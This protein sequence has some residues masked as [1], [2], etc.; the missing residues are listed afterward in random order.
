MFV[1]VSSLHASL[2]FTCKPTRRFRQG[3]LTER[4]AQLSTVDLLVLASLDQLVLK[5]KILF[6]FFTKLATLI[7]RSTILS[8]PHQ[9]VFPDWGVR[10]SLG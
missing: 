6:S 4:K 7:R 10:V 5:L 1:T 9:L 2:I 8:L 3:S